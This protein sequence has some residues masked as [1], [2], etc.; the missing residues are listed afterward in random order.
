ML[1]C[2]CFLKNKFLPCFHLCANSGFVHYSAKAAFAK[3]TL[4]ETFLFTCLSKTMI[5]LCVCVGGILCIVCLWRSVDSFLELVFFF[6]RVYFSGLEK[7]LYPLSHLSGP[8]LPDF[9]SLLCLTYRC[10]P[11]TPKSYLSAGKNYRV[12][13]I[14]GL[15]VFSPPM[16]R[17]SL[18]RASRS[19]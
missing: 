3:G 10:F 19:M 15:V 12:K 18:S 5:Y 4:I 2:I 7:H 9:T 17:K 16:Y 13:K 14:S 8:G 6:Y 11:E 1:F